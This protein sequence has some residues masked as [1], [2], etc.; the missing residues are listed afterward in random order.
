V[1]TQGL[2]TDV[3]IPI[4]RLPRQRLYGGDALN[5]LL[6]P[7]EKVE[8]DSLHGTFISHC[9]TEGDQALINL[10]WAVAYPLSLFRFDIPKFE[11]DAGQVQNRYNPLS[12]TPTS[13]CVARTNVAQMRTSNAIQTRTASR[14]PWLYDSTL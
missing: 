11:F 8:L 14:K 12:Q 9:S 3:G 13:T 7:R 5:S 4:R 10:Q 2:P 6:E 1:A